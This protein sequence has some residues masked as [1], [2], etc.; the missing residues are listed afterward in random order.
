M[1]LGIDHVVLATDDPD[2]A[3]A[4]LERRLG[5]AAAGGGR[6]EALGTFNRLIWLGDA[7]LEL[8]GVFDRDRAA[9]SWL[10]PSVL[11][12]LTRGGGLA[13][14][15]IAVDDL[16]DALRWAPPDAGLV[17]PLDGERQRPDGRIVRWQ[18]A[19]PAA[20]SPVAPFLIEHDVTAAEWSAEERSVRAAEQHPVGGRARLVGVEVQTPSPAVA[21]G[22]LRSV[23]AASVEPA[24][25]AAVRVR[26]GLQEA[27][28]VTPRPSA[29]AIV[30]VIVDVAMRTRVARVGDSEI[31]IRGFAPIETT[32]ADTVET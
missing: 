28:F 11:E 10:G 8:I 13:T 16:D 29:P 6:H 27:R 2:A 20:L 25:R 22:R 7:Y 5:L 15:A 1:L 26:L 32:G 4:E 19:H 21:A 14:W 24:G 18:L 23:L 31:R 30:D 12:A 3:A 9:A 17:G